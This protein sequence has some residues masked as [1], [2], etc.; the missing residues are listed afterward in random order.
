MNTPPK[1]RVGDWVR[2]VLEGEVSYLSATGSFDIDSIHP[3]SPTWDQV[4]SIEKLAKLPTVGTVIPAGELANYHWLLGTVVKDD[5]NTTFMYTL[6]GWVAAGGSRFSTQEVG[7][8]DN[9]V[10]Y[11]P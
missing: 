5:D 1:V 10:V 9:T 2:V 8:D 3:I 7:S 11:L 6:N 4:V